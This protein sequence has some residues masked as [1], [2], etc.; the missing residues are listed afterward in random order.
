MLDKLNIKKGFLSVGLIGLIFQANAEVLVILPE[1]G[2]MA[3]AGNSIKM[4]IEAAHQASKADLQLKFVN[5]DQKIISRV[6]KDNVSRSTQLIIGP[7]ARTDLEGLFKENLK[8]PVLALNEIDQTKN[9]VWQFS[10]SKDDDANALIQVINADKIQQ[11]FVIREKGSEK[12]SLSFVNALYKKFNGEVLIVDEVP[13]LNRNQGVLLLGGNLWINQLNGKPKQRLYAQAISIVDNKS[14][15]LGLKFCDVSVVHT[16]QWKD[17]TE[18]YVKNPTTFAYQ[19][20]YAFGGDAWE[21]AEKF[22]LNP[23]VKQFNFNGKTG[24]IKINNQR[25]EREPQCFE[26]KRKGLVAL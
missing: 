23:D 18:L 26:N 14:I 10:L 20:L 8:I 5:S 3:R 11:I 19:R 21:I 16:G 9:N 2:S 22:V 6:L 25:I 15:P 4:G 17:L 24:D 7:L 13:K 12:D 1:S